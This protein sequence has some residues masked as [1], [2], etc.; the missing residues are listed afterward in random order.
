MAALDKLDWTL[1]SDKESKKAKGEFVDDLNEKSTD[2]QLIYAKLN[3]SLD[4]SNSHITDIAGLKS[5]VAANTAKTGIT[6]SQASAITANTAKTGI[7]TSQSSAITANTAKTGITT[8][9][10]TQLSNLNAGR[11]SGLMTNVNKVT[12]QITQAVTVNAKT[13]AATLDST[14]VLSNGNRYTL[15]QT[16]TR[17]NKK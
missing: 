8:A 3:E 13:G 2:I 17:I 6:T 12:A 7:T 10:A 16:L 11:A 4:K 14:I 9:Q 5:D 1:D 15:S